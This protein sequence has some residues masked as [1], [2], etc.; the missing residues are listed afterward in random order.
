VL[1]SV[2]NVT[3]SWKQRHSAPVIR[4]V[5]PSTQMRVFPEAL[6]LKSEYPAA[7]EGYTRLISSPIYGGVIP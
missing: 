1:R 2:P 4:K 5:A 3:E 6:L 7:S